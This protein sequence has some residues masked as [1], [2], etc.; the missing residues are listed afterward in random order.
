MSN[1]ISR[2]ASNDLKAHI[3]E[4]T[5]E[6][7]NIEEKYASVVPDASTPEGYKSAKEIRGEIVPIKTRME[8]ARKTLKDPV[9]ALGKEIDAAFKPLIVRLENL[10]KPHEEAYRKVDNAK[11]EAAAQ[12]EREA[13]AFYTFITNSLLDAIGA[14][15]E[16][17]TSI[18]EQ[19]S[20]MA[21][22]ESRADEAAA[23]MNE[24]MEKL[25]DLL[26]DAVSEDAPDPFMIE[27]SDYKRGWRDALRKFAVEKDG[28]MFIND[29]PLDE[30][31]EECDDF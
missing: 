3:C 16:K 21:I 11:K 24:A 31:I 7:D 27:E 6:V 4:L 19:V 20:D 15:K 22:P 25:S 10:Y 28:D 17:I 29:T 18:M 2:K 5:L 14:S 8:K 1:L 23:K 9:L 13:E 26:R 12:K 30:A